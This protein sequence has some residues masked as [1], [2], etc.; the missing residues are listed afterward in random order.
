MKY[1][2]RPFNL[3]DA[4]FI[5]ALVFKLRHIDPVPSWFEVFAVYLVEV[6]YTLL[7]RMA[8]Q[9]KWE[10]KLRHWLWKI[11]TNQDIKRRAKQASAH[12][13]YN[14][15]KPGNPGEFYDK[16]KRGTN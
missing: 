16:D 5:V 3:F 2:I 8:I 12:M 14:N 6:V 9:L 4:L 13:R 10:Q 1:P 7:Y 11:T 15:S